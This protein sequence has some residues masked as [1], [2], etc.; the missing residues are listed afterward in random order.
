MRRHR[1]AGVVS[2][3][4]LLQIHRLLSDAFPVNYGGMGRRFAPGIL[5]AH[6]QAVT[7]GHY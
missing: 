4:D 7:P 2:S 3:S 1:Q 5:L 6:S